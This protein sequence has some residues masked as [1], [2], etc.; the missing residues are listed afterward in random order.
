MRCCKSKTSAQGLPQAEPHTAGYWWEGGEAGAPGELGEGGSWPG[1]W[2]YLHYSQPSFAHRTHLERWLHP[3][4]TGVVPG[5]RDMTKHLHGSLSGEPEGRYS[6]I[7]SFFSKPF[8]MFILPQHHLEML[9]P[10]DGF[11]CLLSQK[12]HRWGL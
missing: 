9:G 10:R 7:W 1:R 8:G 6:Q 5:L 3:L 4:A 11:H 2:P 12:R